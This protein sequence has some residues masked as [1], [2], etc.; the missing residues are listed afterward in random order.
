MSP[1][2]F[3]SPSKKYS[4]LTFLLVS[5]TYGYEKVL[6]GV[7]VVN[8]IQNRK[9]AESSAFTFDLGVNRRIIISWTSSLSLLY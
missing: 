1:F 7:S 2:T 4:N 3:S 6:R 9:I 5:M 8:I